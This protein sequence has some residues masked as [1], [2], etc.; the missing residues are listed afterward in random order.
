VILAGRRINDY[1]GNYVGDLTIRA[2]NAAGRLPSEANVWILGMT[3]KENVPDFRNTR[4]V[5]VVQYLTGFECTVTAWEPLVGPES[6]KLH[7]GLDTQTFDEVEGIDAVVLINGHDAFK[8]I[9]LDKLKAKMR[10]PV[11][12][13]VKNFFS[14]SEA[15]ALGFHY[16]GL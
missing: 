12:V 1:M 8:T 14:G 3:F 2:L 9:T 10:T 15:E 6:I 13:D 4:A 5:D 11:L 16:V 7:F